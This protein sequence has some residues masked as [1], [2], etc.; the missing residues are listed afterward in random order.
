MIETH[1]KQRKLKES[2]MVKAKKKQAFNDDMIIKKRK[3]IV[4]SP[5]QSPL[6]ISPDS[7]NKKRSPS[8]K[9]TAAGILVIIIVGV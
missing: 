1:E 4:E 5:N 9:T 2:A 7:S 6:P 8:S 3:R